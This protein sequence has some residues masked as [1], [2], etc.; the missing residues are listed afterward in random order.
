MASPADILAGYYAA[1]GERVRALV[2]APNGKS[3]R[4]QAFNQ[5]RAASILSQVRKL[6]RE[7]KRRTATVTGAAMAGAYRDGLTQARDMAIE[8][9]VVRPDNPLLRGGFSQVDRD[10][11]ALVAR[12]TAASL[13]RAAESYA[14]RVESILRRTGQMAL[15]ESEVNRIIAGG[16]IQGQPTEAIRQLRDE[17]RSVGETVQVRDRNGDIINFEPGYYARMVVITKTREAVVTARHERLSGLG[18]DL[19]MIIGKPS[20]NFCSAFLGQVFSL[21]GQHPR[22]PAYDSLPDG[23]PP[24]HP[25][26]SKGT[27]PF[28][29]ALARPAQLE[30]AEGVPDAQKLLGMSPTQAQ[31]AFKD[32]QLRTQVEAQYK[33]ITPIKARQAA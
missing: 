32:L 18:L 16:I 21:S 20:N 10:A 2:L 5:A 33:R 12:D 29:E 28:V 27:R 7:L 3:V 30:V 25:N 8:T 11:A 15:E 9:G 14:T 6:E 19:V 23:G 13:N 1:T 17:L 26:C 31:R 24:F 22:Y 4:A